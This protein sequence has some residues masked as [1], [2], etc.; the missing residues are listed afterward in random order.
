MLII[1]ATYTLSD[2][3]LPGDTRAGR[4]A[5]WLDGA[6]PALAGPSSAPWWQEVHKDSLDIG[7]GQDCILGQLF[8]DFHR[9]LDLI[10]GPLV[11]SPGLDMA[12]RSVRQQQ[13]VTWAI[14]HGFMSCPRYPW[15]DLINQ[16]LT[17]QP[18]QPF[19]IMARE[20]VA[21]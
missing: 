7:S 16:R 10:Q 9:A 13:R 12:A 14:A 6:Y 19:D 4:G 1:E 21:A 17:G 8:G 2:L 11:I 18:E 15:L 20:V 5:G 3:S